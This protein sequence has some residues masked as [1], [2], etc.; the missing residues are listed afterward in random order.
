MLY[1]SFAAVADYNVPTM[2]LKD[3]STFSPATRASTTDILEIQHR[4]CN[5]DYSSNELTHW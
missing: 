1:D 5:E 2:T 4:Y 3:G